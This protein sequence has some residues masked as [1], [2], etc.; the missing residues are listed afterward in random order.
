MV[1]KHL[2]CFDGIDGSGKSTQIRMIEEALAKRRLEYRT[3]KSPGSSP[4]ANVLR[5]ILFS[6]AF[7]KADPMT[8]ALTHFAAMNETFRKHVM[9]PLSDGVV[10]LMDRWF[11]S[12]L[13]YQVGADTNLARRLARTARIVF[14]VDQISRIYLLDIDPTKARRRL[15]LRTSLDRYDAQSI[16][17]KKQ[18][19]LNYLSSAGRYPRK[20]RV[21]DAERVPT[22]I[23]TEIWTDMQST[24]PS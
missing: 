3:F 17:E 4:V 5:Q 6:T 16:E 15:T 7:A 23:F 20:I 9:Q 1:A 10:I 8:E 2:Y 22:E 13:A 24:L 21:I 14:P 19:R 12:T 11:L 18:I